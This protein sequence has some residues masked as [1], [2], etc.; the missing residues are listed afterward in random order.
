MADRATMRAAVYRKRRD[1]A[2]ELV[3]VTIGPLAEARDESGRVVSY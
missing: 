2:F 3:D 1:G